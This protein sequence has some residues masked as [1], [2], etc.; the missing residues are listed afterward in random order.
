MKESCRKI[1]DFGRS[2]TEGGE[3]LETS[4]EENLEAIRVEVAKLREEYAK[5]ARALRRFY[6]VDFAGE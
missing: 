1:E 2:M 3:R 6:G 4:E 5:V